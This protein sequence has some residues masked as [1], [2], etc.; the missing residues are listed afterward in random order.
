MTVNEA[1]ENLKMILEEAT[2]DE[3]SVCYVTSCDKEGLEMAINALEEQQ[4]IKE[5]GFSDYLLNMGY[6]KGYLE[7]IDKFTEKLME[8]QIFGCMLKDGFRADI[9]TSHTID[10][11]AKLMK[12]GEQL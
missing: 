1:I 10:T 9:V 7:A 6:T 2:E 11:I 5:D 3:H 8:E 4:K 12:A